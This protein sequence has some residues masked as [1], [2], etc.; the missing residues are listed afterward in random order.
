MQIKCAVCGDS[1]MPKRA[2]AKYCGDRCRKRAQ[3]SPRKDAEAS[4]PA[5]TVVPEPESTGEDVHTAMTGLPSAYEAT[6]KQLTTAGRLDTALGAAAL[7]AAFRLD[8]AV[9]SADTGSG[10]KALIDAHRQ[11]LAEATKNAEKADDPVAKI[12][13]AAALKLVAT[14]RR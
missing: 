10:V 5:L 14:G 2:T 8:Q 7:I 6:L 1:F 13:A 4:T 3:R 12:R 11:A 9:Y